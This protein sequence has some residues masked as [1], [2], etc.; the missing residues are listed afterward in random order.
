MGRSVLLQLLLR[1]LDC[2]SIR[3]GQEWEAS[4]FRAGGD[5]RTAEQPGGERAFL[6]SLPPIFQSLL[7]HCSSSS[8]SSTPAAAAARAGTVEEDGDRAWALRLLLLRV[9]LQRADALRPLAEKGL[10]DFVAESVADRRLSG[11]KRLHYW[12]RCEDTSAEQQFSFCPLVNSIPDS[13]TT[14]SSFRFI[15]GSDAILLDLFG[16]LPSQEGTPTPISATGT[17]HTP[18]GISLCTW[19]I[20]YSFSCVGDL[21]LGTSPSSSQSGCTSPQWEEGRAQTVRRP[22]RT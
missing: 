6:L 10:V 7:R 20:G 17:M 19:R 13:Q 9:F 4:A 3:F 16:V 14:H 15:L 18:V 21:C 12:L 2:A 5:N 1:L 11:G 22:T 8:S